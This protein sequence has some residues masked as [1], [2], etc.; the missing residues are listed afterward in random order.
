MLHGGVDAEHLP[1]ELVAN[2]LDIDCPCSVYYTSNA[3][4]NET[5]RTKAH[6]TPFANYCTRQEPSSNIGMDLKQEPHIPISLWSLATA[7]VPVTLV[8]ESLIRTS[9]IDRF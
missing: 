6:V 8:I 2:T 9:H 3:L 7:L 1:F 4:S 5:V